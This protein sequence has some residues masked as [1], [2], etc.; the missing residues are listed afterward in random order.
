MIDVPVAAAT[1][2]AVPTVRPEVR[3]TEAARELSEPG[4]AALV[5]LEAGTVAGVVNRRQLM[6]LLADEGGNPPV[7][8]VVRPPETTFSPE[9]SVRDAAE[10]MR[11]DGVDHAP[12]VEEGTYRGLVTA[13]SLA[14]FVPRYR[15]PPEADDRPTGAEESGARGGTGPAGRGDEGVGAPH[16]GHPYAE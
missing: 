14:P 15:L 3:V 2:A 13:A 7:G 1:T 11:A 12:V 9:T 4:V 5:V 6:R 16:V 8:A 10:R